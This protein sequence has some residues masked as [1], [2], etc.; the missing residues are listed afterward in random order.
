[1]TTFIT[2]SASDE[3]V[4]RNAGFAVLLLARSLDMNPWKTFTISRVNW[5]SEIT[6][7]FLA[8]AKSSF[9]SPLPFFPSLPARICKKRCTALC[10]LVMTSG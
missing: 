7:S 9:N 6:P 1:M 4:G 10:A 5:F 8:S 2:S 3:L